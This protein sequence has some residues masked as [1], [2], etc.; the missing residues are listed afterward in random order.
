M[1]KLGRPSFLVGLT[2]NFGAGKS[3]VARF[4]KEKG[5]HVLN[6]DRLAHEVYQ[7]ENRFHGK[8]YLLFPE[9]EGRL[10]RERISKIVFQDAQKRRSLERLIHPYVFNRIREEIKK[11]PKPIVILEVPL[12]FESGFYRETDCNVVV[13]AESQTI[14]GRLARKGYEKTEVEA[15]WRAQMPLSEKIRRSDYLVDNSDGFKRT[16]KQ[17][18]QIWKKI[19]RS[20][21]EHG[22]R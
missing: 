2:G 3:T 21:L 6:A 4:F 8:L 1:K 15:R 11:T 13:K 9:L 22:Q 12:L 10:N 20:L 16:R 17:V 19:E 5:A 18:V 7:K 14:L